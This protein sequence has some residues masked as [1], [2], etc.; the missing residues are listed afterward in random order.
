MMISRQILVGLFV[1]LG[2]GAS[3]RLALTAPFAADIPP[4]PAPA[5]VRQNAD[6]A[7]RINR[8]LALR[9]VSIQNVSLLQPS[10]EVVSARIDVAG[11]S[12]TLDLKKHSVRSPDFQVLVQTDASGALHPHPA[13]P[14]TTYRGVVRE[15]PGTEVRVRL[16]DGHLKGV[17]F[18]NEDVLGIQPLAELDPAGLPGDHVVYKHSDMIPDETHK[19]G[20]F[21]GNGLRAHLLEP[22]PPMQRYDRG[23]EGSTAG[24]NLKIADIALDADFEFYVLNGSNVNNTVQDMENV[25]SGLEPYYEV[26]AI[27]ITYEI[28]TVIVRTTAGAPYTSTDPGVLLENQFRATWMT[29]PYTFIRR[30]TAHLFTGKNIDSSVIGIAYLNGICSTNIGYGLSESRFTSNFAARLA[31]TAHE[32]GHNWSAPHCDGC[33]SCSQCC[34]IMCSGLGGCTGV[35][36][37]FGCE[38]VAVIAAFKNTRGCLSDQRPTQTVPFFEDFSSGTIDNLRWS[39]NDGAAISTAAVNPPSGTHV[40]EL[41]ASGNDLYR[42]DDLRTNFIDLTGQ[43]NLRLS[44]YTQHRGPEAGEALVVEYWQSG[45]NWVELNRIT[46]DG[47]MQTAFVFHTHTLPANAYHSEFRVRFRPEVNETNDDWF[48]DDVIVT[49]LCADDTDCNDLK[50]CNGEETCGTLGCLPGA[51]PCGSQLCR[52][53]DDACVQ[54]LGPADCSDGL[55][56]NGAEFCNI[57]GQCIPASGSPC[58]NPQEPVCDEAQ[59]RC[60]GCITN[61]DCS[62]GLFC[63]GVETCTGAQTCS[64][65]SSPCPGQACNENT[66]QC[67][68]PGNMTP[69]LASS[70]AVPGSMV[71]VFVFADS[72]HEIK[73]FQASVTATRTSGTGN[74]TINCPGGVV[75]SK[76]RPDYIFNGLDDVSSTNCNLKTATSQLETGTVFV[77]STPVYLATFRITVS[78][79]AAI[80]STFDVE[81]GNLSFL[82]DSYNLGQFFNRGITTLT[83]VDTICDPPAVSAEGSRALEIIPANNPTTQALR[84]TSPDWPCLSKYVQFDGSL[85]ATSVAQSA[86]AWGAV[87][88]TGPEI[89]PA[90]HYQ[91]R[92]ECGT[93]TSN[94]V[95]AVTT[96]WG[97]LNGIPPVDVG[98]VLCMLEGYAGVFTSCPFAAV[99]I[100]PCDPDGIVELSDVTAILGAYSGGNMPCPPP[101]P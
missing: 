6:L 21:D 57:A 77:G 94:T 72:V 12:W 92:A 81:V 42:D 28:T 86:G 29:S 1:F 14:I 22:L 68:P 15:Q 47:S 46:S 31:L 2:V 69:V 97:E 49:N 11:E 79:D 3:A 23:S 30:D 59:D 53:S 66:D 16:I 70:G 10:A 4:Q 40:V 67:A 33:N 17:I 25:I 95:S 9:R 91:V 52:E 35:L 80:G 34:R 64:T 93:V 99:D 85:G 56:C 83:V 100:A 39:Y 51:Y 54:C 50:Y 98:D 7:E 41:D 19:C 27:G 88:A 65:G 60:V 20:T 13:P 32:L 43:S 38:E 62:D 76:T 63:N 58:T 48:L 101:C 37:S 78:A 45:Q 73:T 90:S 8:Q 55:F 36:T 87:L 96:E 82:R 74:A 18:T 61:A 24:T 26:P 84:V 71:N 75:I 44:Y 89:F 5:L